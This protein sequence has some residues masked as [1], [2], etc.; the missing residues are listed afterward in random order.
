MD[1]G[2]IEKSGDFRALKQDIDRL[3]AAVA[4]HARGRT[5]P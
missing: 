3:I 2:R 1:E 4:S 5:V